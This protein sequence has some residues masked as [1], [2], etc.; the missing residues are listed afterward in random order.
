MTCLLAGN[1]HPS[2]CRFGTYTR[3]AENKIFGTSYENFTLLQYWSI[4]AELTSKYRSLSDCSQSF[5]SSSTGSTC[6]WS[7]VWKAFK[8]WCNFKLFVIKV[9]VSACRK[10]ATFQALSHI[11]KIRASRLWGSGCILSK[12]SCLQHF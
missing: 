6:H 7:K 3:I 4:M 10:L 1:N 11:Q 8:S 12:L 2:I 9:L 5:K